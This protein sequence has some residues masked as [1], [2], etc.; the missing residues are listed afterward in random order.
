M[1]VAKSAG[2][3]VCPVLT[4]RKA[5]VMRLYVVTRL[6]AD[7]FKMRFHPAD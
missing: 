5:H 3:R 2:G 7:N 4:M 6:F 1:I